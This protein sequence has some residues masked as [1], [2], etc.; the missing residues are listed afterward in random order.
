MSAPALLRPLGAGDL[1]DEAVWLYRKNFPRFVL[2]VA[3]LRV[4]LTLLVSVFQTARDTVPFAFTPVNLFSLAVNQLLISTLLSAVFAYAV[5]AR[6][7]GQTASLST[8]YLLAA[9]RSFRLLTNAVVANIAYAL[10]LAATTLCLQ[11]AIVALLNPFA[12]IADSDVLSVAAALVVFGIYACGVALPLL[13]L[14]ARW[15]V[16]QQVI[17]LEDRGGLQAFGR[18][19]LLMRGQYRRVMFFLLGLFMLGSLLST[20]PSFLSQFIAEEIS[21]TFNRDSWAGIASLLFGFAIPTLLDLLF[22]PVSFVA[23]TLLYYDLRVRAEGYDL[24][25][26]VARWAEQAA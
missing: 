13:A 6:L 2:I 4:P 7:S 16:S 17:A 3:L 25:V 20:A 23:R 8:V 10:V 9:R 24:S 1:L 18:S 26:R 11:L 19:A 12:A 22:L 21:P 14:N 15:S 5:S